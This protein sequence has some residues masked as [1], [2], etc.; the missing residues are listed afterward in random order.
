MAQVGLKLSHLRG[1]HIVPCLVLL[2][3]VFRC[4]VCVPGS[5]EYIY[6]WA[7]V[8]AGFPSLLFSTLKKKFFFETVPHVA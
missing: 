8:D 2:I 3:A 6:V 4:G 5:E 7:E 1:M